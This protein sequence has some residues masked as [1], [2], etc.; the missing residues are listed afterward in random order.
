MVSKGPEL[1]EVPSVVG[2][3]QDEAEQILVDAGFE[4]E[5]DYPLGGAVFYTVYSQS[6]PGGTML[7]RGTT[8]TL[9]I[10]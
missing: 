3:Q 6:E 5:I 4:V 2:K 10:V 8:I 9:Q 7:R 1:L